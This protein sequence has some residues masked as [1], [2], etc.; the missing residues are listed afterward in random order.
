[1]L[2]KILTAVIPKKV[3]IVLSISVAVI[4]VLLVQS[5]KANA[6]LK[7]DVKQWQ[8]ASEHWSTAYQALDAKLLEREQSINQLRSKKQKIKTIIKE[9]KDD[10]NCLDQPLP[11]DIRWLFIE[12]DN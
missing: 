9:V 5:W 4:A 12:G 11:D 2:A 8:A 7:R 10:T 1:M 6:L 3:V